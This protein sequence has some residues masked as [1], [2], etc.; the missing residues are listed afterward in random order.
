MEV[1]AAPAK[2]GGRDL[3]AAIGVGVAMGTAVVLSLVIAKGAFVGLVAIALVV[4]IWEITNA[5]GTRGIRVPIAVGA[6]GMLI[7]AYDGGTESLVVG[8]ALTLIGVIVWRLTDG[9]DGYVRD[10]TAGLFTAVYVPFLGSFAV[11]L[12]RPH[13]GAARVATYI[14]LTVC[15]D[16]G[17]YCT[18]AKLGRH[19]MC[20]TVSP[21]KS[22]EGFAG[23]VLTCMAAGAVCLVVLLDD[24]WWKGLVVGAAAALAATVGDLGESV[25]KRDL[26]VKDMGTLLPGHG[27]LMDRLDSLLVTAPVLWLLLSACV[28]SG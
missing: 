23:S 10:V 24:A 25:L 9:P 12:D 27:G 1:R 2:K 13:D 15:N 14:I 20:P 4:A 17:G 22:W 19:P 26:G 28:D 7:A 5:L 11:L 21:K 18:G 3:P 8:L 6:V 16:V